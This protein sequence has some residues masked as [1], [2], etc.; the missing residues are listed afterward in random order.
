MLFAFFSCFYFR[1][2]HLSIFHSFV[3]CILFAF[4]FYFKIGTVKRR[5]TCWESSEFYV[6][7]VQLGH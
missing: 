4:T 6:L 1:I 3:M 5:C 2:E 7:N